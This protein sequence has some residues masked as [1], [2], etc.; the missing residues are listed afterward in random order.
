MRIF[1]GAGALVESLGQNQRLTLIP[2]ASNKRC[3]CRVD[4]RRALLTASQ[5][6]CAFD[7]LSMI[8][9]CARSK[10]A[11]LDSGRPEPL[12]TMCRHSS[13]GLPDFPGVLQVVCVV[14]AE[15]VL[16]AAAQISR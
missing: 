7:R 6:S 11:P 13:T 8:Y 2:I 15:H 16:G 4:N 10:A 1:Q 14:R 5:S 12:W 9:A 3:R